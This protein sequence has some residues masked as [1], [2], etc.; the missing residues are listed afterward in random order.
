MNKIIEE[1]GKSFTINNQGTTV[2][3]YIALIGQDCIGTCEDGF[4]LAVVT[5]KGDVFG[6]VLKGRVDN[7]VNGATSKFSLYVQFPEHLE[8]ATG[9]EKDNAFEQVLN[10]VIKSIDSVSE[11]DTT[12]VKLTP[13]LV[14]SYGVNQAIII[15]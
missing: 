7:K 3:T 14:T 2:E 6:I 15:E 9:E 13:Y 12:I 10:T 5:D 8:N 4:M 11:P 1:Q